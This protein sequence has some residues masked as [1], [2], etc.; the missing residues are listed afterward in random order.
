MSQHFYQ[1]QH[2]GK[3]VIVQLGYDRPIGHV[4]MVVQEA[5][6]QHDPIYSNLFQADPFGLTLTDY[7]R[8]LADLQITV[9]ETMFEQ[10]ELD[11]DFNVGNRVVWY[12]ADGSYEVKSDELS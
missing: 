8:V 1:T 7:R 10:V 3:E 12:E 9:P 2:Q 4:F 5:S 11:A 6:G